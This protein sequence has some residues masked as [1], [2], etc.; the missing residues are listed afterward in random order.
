MSTNE[1]PVPRYMQI[2]QKFR[3]RILAGDLAEGDTIPSAREIALAEH[4]ALATATRVH[5]TLRAE[6]LTQ[7]RPGVGT[8]VRLVHL[9]ARDRSQ[10]V[11]TSGRIY[12]SGHYAR[13]LSADL[14]H[15]PDHVVDALR[16]DPGARAIRR[17]R[18]TFDANDR[19]LSM[20]VS[21]FD[22]ALAES[23]PALLST[24]RILEGTARYVEQRSG[25]TRSDR[26]QL[27]LSAGHATAEEALQLDLPEGSAVLRGRNL[28]FDTAGGVIE[29]GES[30][31]RPDLET[32][33][34][35]ST[36]TENR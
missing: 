9:S 3:D 35:Y 10:L 17:R 33:F 19:P 31:G 30:A 16:L 18:T 12:P 22:G 7:A 6:G 14:V 11:L 27:F 21:W 34:D 20:S 26:E 13:I 23:A 15:A 32:R 1:R 29:Y 36:S 5:A 25:R 28:Y 2:A 24:E 8:V 4:V